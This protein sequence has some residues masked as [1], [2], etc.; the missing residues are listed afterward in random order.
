MINLIGQMYAEN[1]PAFGKVWMRKLEAAAVVSI[2][3]YYMCLLYHGMYLSIMMIIRSEKYRTDV[4]SIQVNNTELHCS[5]IPREQ[6]TS[7]PIIVS[8]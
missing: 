7:L 5:D 3:N 2:H 6:S 4:L 1:S 8:T